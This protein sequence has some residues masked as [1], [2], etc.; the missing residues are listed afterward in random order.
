VLKHNPN[1]KTQKRTSL[2]IRITVKYRAGNKIE[3]S[4]YIFFF[5]YVYAD[6]RFHDR[7]P[8]A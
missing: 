8:I 4:M 6:G 3:S 5:F 1:G 2:R 7:D